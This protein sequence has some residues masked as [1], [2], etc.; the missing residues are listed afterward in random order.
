LYDSTGDKEIT[1]AA[2]EA[3]A[4]AEALGSDGEDDDEDASGWVN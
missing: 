1:Q 4:M 3:M 2:D